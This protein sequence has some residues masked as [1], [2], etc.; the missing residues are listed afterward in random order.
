M[1]ILPQIAFQGIMKV[2][3]SKFPEVHYDRLPLVFPASVL[4]PPLIPLPSLM[5]F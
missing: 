4:L 2:I 3:E 1:L 5:A